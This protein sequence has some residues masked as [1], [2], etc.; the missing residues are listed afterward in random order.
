VL[1]DATQVGRGGRPEASL[2]GIGDLGPLPAAIGFAGDALN[3]P[4]GDEPVDEARGAGS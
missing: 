1:G 4:V 2:A 3:E